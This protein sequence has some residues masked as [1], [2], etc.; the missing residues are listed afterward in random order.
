[1]EALFHSVYQNEEP[2]LSS[3]QQQLRISYAP[4]TCSVTRPVR[5]LICLQLR[6]KFAICN[7]GAKTFRTLPEIEA[8]P[9]TVIQSFLGYDKTTDVFKVLCITC[10]SG[11][12]I[13][14]ITT[15]QVCTIRFTAGEESW[16]P[17]TCEYGHKPL[18]EGLFINGVLYYA[19]ER[20]SDKSRVI[21]SFNVMSEE[22]SV[23][24][25][26]EQ[27][28]SDYGLHLVNYHGKI[29]LSYFVNY[30]TGGLQMWVRNE[31]GEWL[32]KKN[33]KIPPWKETVEDITFSFRGTINGT[34][35]LVFT[36]NALHGRK[37]LPYI[38]LFYDP[39]EKNLRRFDIENL[40]GRDHV[41][42]FVD[43]V[44]STWLM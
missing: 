4:L 21:M 1:M 33:I 32:P 39:E 28:R 42:T 44:D 15:Y 23:I 43:H 14:L 2:L 27:V 34:N 38:V 18:T 40:E 13:N 37:G 12:F 36:E 24:E 26:S 3:G 10:Q 9:K 11:I 29:A 25:L 5:G 16:R 20:Y 7:P 22:F 41:K 31:M 8:D 6:N 17:I 19:A 30:K 35:E